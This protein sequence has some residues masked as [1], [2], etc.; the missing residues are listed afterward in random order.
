MILLN[1]HVAISLIGIFTGF[2]VLKGM[3][4][5]RRLDSMNAVF[6]VTT[7]ATSVTGYLLPADKLLPSHII[8]ALSLIVLV[9]AIYARYSKQLSGSWARNYVITAMIAQYFNVFV[10]VVQ[11]F[12]NVAPLHALAPTESE[13][14][15]A[16]AQLIVLGAFIYVTR[17]AIKSFQAT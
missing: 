9:I 11:T 7:V 13:P 17:R 5:N 6:L 15:F 12:R 8:G 3:W 14:P 1:L 10:L 16:V 4:E 2:L